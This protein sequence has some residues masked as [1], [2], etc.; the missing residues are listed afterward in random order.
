MALQG[1]A[2]VTGER[3]DDLKRRLRTGTGA[4]RFDDR[5]WELRWAQKP[6][7]IQSGQRPSRWIWK[8]G[9]GCDCSGLSALGS[10]RQP[11]CASADKS[12][13]TAKSRLCGAAGASERAV[14]PHLQYRHRPRLDLFAQTSSIR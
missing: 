9:T 7:L 4:G 2:A 1:A 3:G 12:L 5:N 14:H 13:A 6:P 11:C 8:S 10:L